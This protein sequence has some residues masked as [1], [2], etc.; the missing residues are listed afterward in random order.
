VSTVHSYI[1]I[2][3]LVLCAALIDTDF[4]EYF[5]IPI[6]EVSL[7]VFESQHYPLTDELSSYYAWQTLMPDGYAYVH[8]GPEQRLFAISMAHQLHCLGALRNAI[9]D[10]DKDKEFGTLG[11]SQHCLNYLRQWILCNP[12]LT[13]EPFDPLAKDY[14]MERLGATHVCRD[15]SAVYQGMTDNLKMYLRMLRDQAN[16]I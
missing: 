5:T 6:R 8:L 14:N 1:T 15:W 4:P 7:T 9:I 16:E 2:F 11:H 12:D 3:I 10:P 13:L